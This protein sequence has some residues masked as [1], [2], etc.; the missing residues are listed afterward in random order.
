MEFV[1]KIVPDSP[2][3]QSASLDRTKKNIYTKPYSLHL[4]RGR[5]VFL[6]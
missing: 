1:W 6:D 4:S 3:I 5:K 2:Y